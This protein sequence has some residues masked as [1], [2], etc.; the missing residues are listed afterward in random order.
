MRKLIFMIASIFFITPS[1]G[2]YKG[3]GIHLS[4]IIG[5]SDAYYGFITNVQANSFRS[6][7]S[8]NKSEIKKGE[9]VTPSKDLDELVE[10]AISNGITPVLI[11]DY[12][13]ILYS[14]STVYNKRIMSQSELNGYLNYFRWVVQHYKGKKIIFE[15]WNEWDK[16]YPKESGKSDESAEMYIKMIKECRNI[17]K[18]YNS[19]SLLIAGGFN[20]LDSNDLNWGIKLQDKGILDYID[21]YSMHPYDF[22]KYYTESPGKS[23]M[24]L[25]NAYNFMVKK[26]TGKHKVNFYITEVGIPSYPNSSLSDAE[27]SNYIKEYFHLAMAKDFIKGVWWYDLMDDG[28]DIKNKEHNF[29]LLTHDWKKKDQAA[30]FSNIDLISK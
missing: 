3:V 8:W 13:N 21:G 1:Y 16:G 14:N 19:D 25:T 22:N 18:E 24:K 2:F 4:P 28:K 20:P 10:K 26:D 23:I 9:Y 29:G 12:N 6:D 30:A 5:N 17:L 15:V 11:I 27:I 7:Y